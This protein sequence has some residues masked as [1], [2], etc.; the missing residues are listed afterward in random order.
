MM[1]DALSQKINSLPSIQ[2]IDTLL[3]NHLKKLREE[4][5]A[6][7]NEELQKRDDKISELEN[8]IR[9]IRIET[10]TEE[11]IED[12]IEEET[13][14]YGDG[15]VVDKEELDYLSSGDSI[16][17]HL[18]PMAVVP[19]NS[20]NISLRG[21][22]T[23][24]VRECI[25]EKLRTCNVK[26]I[27]IHSGSN[28]IPQKPADE[29]ANELIGLAKSIK[30][31]TPNTKVVISGILPKLHCSL[32]P[33]I[34]YIYNKLDRNQRR[35]GYKFARHPQFCQYGVFKYQLFMYPEVQT[36]RPIHISRAGES[37]LQANLKH[38]IGL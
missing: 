34:N 20:V 29:V 15:D 1:S 17:M 3:S 22:S 18:D 5:R 16:I 4:I 32:N 13:W 36:H 21:K 2:D 19:G 37:C 8:Q 25:K 6:E 14:D 26:V 24:E 11:D 23:A 12:L 27:S 28:S 33:G 35:F 30:N 38:A 31:K 10:G 9:S 7:F